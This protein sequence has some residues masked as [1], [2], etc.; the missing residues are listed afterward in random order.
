LIYLAPSNLERIRFVTGGYDEIRYTAE[1]ARSIKRYLSD[2]PCMIADAQHKFKE[3]AEAAAGCSL[4]IALNTNFSH[5]Y[6]AAGTVCYFHP[7]DSKSLALA[8]A[9]A[10]NLTALCP[11]APTREKSVVDGMSI[12]GTLC[13]A[14][15]QLPRE[16]GITPVLIEVN[17]HDNPETCRWLIGA[18]DEIAKCIAETILPFA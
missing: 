5:D 18:S 7:D 16:Q 4:Y 3:R 13:V 17:A 8:T 1:L 10:N 2:Y 6:K 14:E 9:L 15:I 11:I 12:Y